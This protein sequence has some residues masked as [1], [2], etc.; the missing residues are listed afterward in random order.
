MP[1]KGRSKRVKEKENEEETQ[2]SRLFTEIVFHCVDL[3]RFLSFGVGG[4]DRRR[5]GH[6]AMERAA[7]V[8]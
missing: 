7:A 5:M 8:L 3:V 6:V 4:G 2:N 1:K